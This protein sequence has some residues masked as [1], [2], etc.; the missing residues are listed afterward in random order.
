VALPVLDLQSL[1]GGSPD[2]ST[3]YACNGSSASTIADDEVVILEFISS[4]TSSAQTVTSITN[5]GTATV[6]SWTKLFE[7]SNADNTISV[8]YAHQTVKGTIQPTINVNVALQAGATNGWAAIVSSYTGA[9]TDQSLAAFASTNVTVQTNGP[10]AQAVTT[11]AAD[12]LVRGCY[13]DKSTPVGGD[14]NGSAGTNTSQRWFDAFGSMTTSHWF[15]SFTGS[16]S[17]PGSVT[18]TCTGFTTPSF[19]GAVA[20]YEILAFAAP[21]EIGLNPRLLVPPGQLAPSTIPVPAFQFADP[22]PPPPIPETTFDA[23]QL[24]P[25]GNIAPSTWPVAVDMPQGTTAWAQAPT[26][27]IGIVDSVALDQGKGIT[28]LIGIVDSQA[29]AQS[30]TITDLIGI[31]DSVAVDQG[32]STTDLIGIVDSVV[33]DQGKTV[34]DLLGIVDSEDEDVTIILSD[35]AI[36]ILDSSTA[37]KGQFAN[38]TIGIVDSTALNQG[39]TIVDPVGMVDSTPV[40]QFKSATDPIGLVD[41]VIVDQFKTATDPVGLL[42]GATS[43]G[44]S[45]AVLTQTVNDTVG[46]SDVSAPSG[47]FLF[48]EFTKIRQATTPPGGWP[49]LRTMTRRRQ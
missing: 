17:A 30:Q 6:G 26:D 12:S 14:G 15:T 40:D 2:V 33:V 24:M 18:Q 9:K 42:D 35:G 34:V 47:A 23:R 28:D 43:V 8:W 13:N 32:K 46:L 38:D 36:G 16:T 37:D 10:V 11:T 1:N 3:A 27:L 4:K 49:G 48:R 44:G 7:V 39:K 22:P 31:V 45:G 5:G 29:I 20:A 19:V 21:A 25:P 41:S